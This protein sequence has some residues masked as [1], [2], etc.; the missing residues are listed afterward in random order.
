MKKK[1]GEEAVMYPHPIC[2]SL[3]GNAMLVQPGRL[4]VWP[5]PTFQDTFCHASSTKGLGVR[6]YLR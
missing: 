2:P 6:S 4:K 5:C 3:R 1:Y